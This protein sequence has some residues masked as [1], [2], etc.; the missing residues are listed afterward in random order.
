M[1]NSLCKLTASTTIQTL[2][3]M[4]VKEMPYLKEM[5]YGDLPAK[6]QIADANQTLVE[7]G[8]FGTGG[9]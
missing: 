6:Y 3:I 5:S 4:A 1:K 2:T 9:N 7:M 8:P